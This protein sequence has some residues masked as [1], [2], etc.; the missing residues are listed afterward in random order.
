MRGPVP[1]QKERTMYRKEITTYI[2]SILFIAMAA[3]IQLVEARGNCL[4]GKDV[5]FFLYAL[6]FLIWAK[7][8]KTACCAPTWRGDLN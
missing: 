7:K 8:W 5:G 4:Y 2:F 3:A 1:P 6:V